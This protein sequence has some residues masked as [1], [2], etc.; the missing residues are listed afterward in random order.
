MAVRK[1]GTWLFPHHAAAV[2]KCKFLFVIISDRLV[3]FRKIAK[4][5][6]Q[7]RHVW[8]SALRMEKLGSHWTDFH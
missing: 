8:S 5:D 6:Y 1:L 4:S 3:A 7:L 2:R